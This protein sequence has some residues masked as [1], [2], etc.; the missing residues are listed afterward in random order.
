MTT[1][2]SSPRNLFGLYSHIHERYADDATFLWLLRCIAVNQP[3]YTA[4]DL[5]ELD[6]R[7]DAQL[8]GLMT[9]PEESWR[10]CVAALELQQ[11]DAVFTAAVLAFRSL[12]IRHI[13]QVVEA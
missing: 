9:A 3:H 7:I 2:A 13:Q 11:P 6:N 10:I 8:D 1:E 12:D 4:A 5:A